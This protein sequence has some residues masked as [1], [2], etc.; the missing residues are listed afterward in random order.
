MYHKNEAKDISIFPVVE[1]IGQ[2]TW[3]LGKK[4]TPFDRSMPSY[5]ICVH[6]SVTSKNLGWEKIDGQTL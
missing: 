3:Q 6:N 2:T 4:T 5:R 1:D